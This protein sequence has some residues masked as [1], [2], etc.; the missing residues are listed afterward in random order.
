MSATALALVSGATPAVRSQ[1]DPGREAGGDRVGGG[2]DHAVVGG[3][4]HDVDLVDPA[5]PKPIRQ[6]SAGFVGALEAAVRRRVPALG[7]YGFHR[8]VV[9]LRMEVSARRSD[10]TVPRPRCREVGIVG[11]VVAGID[12]EILRR[13]DVVVSARGGEEFADRVRHRLAADHFEGAAFAEI[14]LHVDDQE[15]PHAP[16]LTTRSWPPPPSRPPADVPSTEGDR[17]WPAAAGPPRRSAGRSRTAPGR[18]A[19]EA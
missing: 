4:A 8:G 18:P 13:D 14:V 15:R 11:E 12:V 3:D 5:L 2:G 16:N 9:E 17:T 6:S 7:E 1:Q 19:R 10:H